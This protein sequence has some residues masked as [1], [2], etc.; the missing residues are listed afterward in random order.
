MGLRPAQKYRSDNRAVKASTPTSPEDSG[1][2]VSWRELSSGHERTGRISNHQALQELPDSCLTS[3]RDNARREGILR[4]FQP[5]GIRLASA[6]Q[7]ERPRSGYPCSVLWACKEDC[8]LEGLLPTVDP[9]NTPGENLARLV[10]TTRQLFSADICLL[11][12]FDPAHGQLLVHT[13]C[14]LR[15]RKA[16]TARFAPGDGLGVL[17]TGPQRRG[18][19]S[20]P[21]G[22][23]L[24]SDAAASTVIGPE[25]VRHCMAAAL[26]VTAERIGGLYVM[27]RRDEVFTEGQLEALAVMSHLVALETTR[28]HLTD[29]SGPL[30]ERERALLATEHEARIEARSRSQ[31]LANVSHEI[32]TSVNGILGMTDFLLEGRL[33]ADQRDHAQTLRN[34]GQALL[35]LINDLLDYAKI[36]AGKLELERIEFDLRDALDEMMEMPAVKA[37]QKGLMFACVVDRAVPTVLRGDC[38]RLRQVLYNLADNAVKFTEHGGIVIRVE[39]VDPA[40]EARH[41]DSEWTAPTAVDARDVPSW[42]YCRLLFTL[43]D[44]GIGIAP[45]RMD[46]LFKAFSQADAST[47]RKYGGTGLGLAISGK[48]VELMGGSIHIEST[49]GKGSTFTFSLPFPH[50][51]A[52]SPLA[53]GL[54]PVL[55]RKRVLVVATD[56]ADRQS[57]AEKLASW[58]LDHELARDAGQALALLREAAAGHRPFAIAIV[59]LPGP[60]THFLLSEQRGDPDLE[61]LRFV[62]TAPLHA[63]ALPSERDRRVTELRKPVKHRVLLQTLTALVENW[64]ALRRL[65][66]STAGTPHA[67]LPRTSTGKRV[68]VA[69]D[70]PINQKVTV[71][72]LA[73]LGYDADIAT[74]GRQAVEAVK[75]KRYDLVLMDIQM[76]ELDGYEA[77]AR[78]RTLERKGQLAHGNGET[79]S[80]EAREPADGATIEPEENRPPSSRSGR[81][82]VVAMTAHALAGDRQRAIAAGMD[83]YLAKPVSLDEL[84]RILELLL[85][86]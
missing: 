19:V 84:R 7:H 2:S 28:A 58:T 76:P 14:G 23:P 77:T 26:D 32:R 29:L 67:D 46:R 9:Q 78:I 35:V 80:P 41:G 64:G 79:P 18:I 8:L 74:T 82:P 56:A 44:T 39:C 43:S 42:P 55:R 30:C 72:L 16:R 6:R 40:P 83:E 69:E 3:R 33:N 48:L 70:N 62:V 65:A 63:P 15:T 12:L 81:L 60:D 24:P 20:P 85:R 22:C 21:P 34:C 66:A 25:R 53:A 13:S 49:E 27:S 45:D 37:Q 52:L 10:R 17:I 50:N 71:R 36:E 1:N 38:N 47:T 61:P 31:F 11:A 75:A 86:S 54:S 68:L 73:K 51:E 57:L 4:R 59:D 5:T